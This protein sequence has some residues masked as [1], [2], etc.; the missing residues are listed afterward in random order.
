MRR[1]CV[2]WRIGSGPGL[3]IF[4]DEEL[5]EL[6]SRALIALD[7]LVVFGSAALFCLALA[8]DVV[9]WNMIGGMG[10]DPPNLWSTGDF[11]EIQLCEC[12]M[13]WMSLMAVSAELAE[14]ASLCTPDRV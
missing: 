5:S 8:F 14:E 13:R 10:N 9:D 2:A 7:F 4:G 11:G 3:D 1:P 12:C 6:V